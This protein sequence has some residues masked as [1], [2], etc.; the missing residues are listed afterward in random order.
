MGNL[1]TQY[2]VVWNSLW[3][4][5]FK[6]LTFDFGGIKTSGLLFG[7]SLCM[8]WRNF[9]ASEPFKGALLFN[10]NGLRNIIYKIFIKTKQQFPQMCKKSGADVPSI[11]VDVLSL[12]AIK[13]QIV[14]KSHLLC[15][16]H[17]TVVVYPQKRKQLIRFIGRYICRCCGSYKAYYLNGTT[18]TEMKGNFRSTRKIDWKIIF[19]P[20]F[21]K[22]VHYVHIQY[23]TK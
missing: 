15:T 10:L 16:V 11:V 7:N 8:R 9:L 4:I 18:G 23:G 21:Y 2:A 22:I 20:I 1:S 13:N 14:L 5:N 3:V 6:T 17:S 12:V 19:V